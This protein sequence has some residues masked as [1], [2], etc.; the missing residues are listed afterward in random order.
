MIECRKCQ[1]SGEYLN[2][3][4]YDCAGSGEI[5]EIAYQTTKP[6]E[7]SHPAM[8]AERDYKPYAYTPPNPDLVAKELAEQKRLA[9]E[10]TE[11]PEPKEPINPMTCEH[12][13]EEFSFHRMCW[14]CGTFEAQVIDYARIQAENKA[15]VHAQVMEEEN[16]TVPQYLRK[17]GARLVW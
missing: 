13:F 1:G 6:S 3:T 10:A 14:K 11:I 2:G 7:S 17:V 5:G 15:G 8:R 16:L 9:Q 4:C 12:E